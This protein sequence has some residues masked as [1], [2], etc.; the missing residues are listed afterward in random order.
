MMT[1]NGEEALKKRNS[2]KTNSRQKAGGKN[3]HETDIG[4]QGRIESSS[5][6]VLKVQDN[7]AE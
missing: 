3:F 7:N 6:M 4:L 1:C 5:L 2:A